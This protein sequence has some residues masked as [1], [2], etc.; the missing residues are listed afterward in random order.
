MFKTVNGT[1]ALAVCSWKIPICKPSRD[2]WLWNCCKAGRCPT[3]TYPA[4]L[5]SAGVVTWHDG[6]RRHMDK[7]AIF[8]ALLSTWSISHAALICWF[9]YAKQLPTSWRI[10]CTVSIRIH[11]ICEYSKQLLQCFSLI[12]FQAFRNLY[13]TVHVQAFSSKYTTNLHHGHIQ[14]IRQESFRRRYKSASLPGSPWIWPQHRYS[15]AV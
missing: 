11:N 2:T 13:K 3:E 4:S 1:A 15:A 12:Q 5:S 10:N 6:D 8:P 7:Q 9:Q 14:T